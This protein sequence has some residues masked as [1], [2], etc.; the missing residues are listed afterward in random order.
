MTSVAA[1]PPWRSRRRWCL[2]GNGWAQFLVSL[3]EAS[4]TH[5]TLTFHTI[6]GSAKPSKDF[7]AK[8]GPVTFRR[9]R[10]RRP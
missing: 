5:T 1:S 9:A 10:S 3:S 8:T 6:A 7:V 2:E 4:A